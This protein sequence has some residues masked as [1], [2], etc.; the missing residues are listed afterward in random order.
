MANFSPVSQAEISPR[1]PEQIFLK[2]VCDYMERLSA[3]AEIAGT[4][5]CIK[6]YN[7]NFVGI[8]KQNVRKKISSEHIPQ[9]QGDM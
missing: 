2:D 9:P 5:F 1:P 7:E 8:L 4:L 6:V 3:R